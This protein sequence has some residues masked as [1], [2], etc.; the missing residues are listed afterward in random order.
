[1]SEKEAEGYVLGEARE[2][3]EQSKSL[4]EE[5]E[6]LASR[7]SAVDALEV[8]M[9]TVDRAISATEMVDKAKAAFDQAALEGRTRGLNQAE[10]GLASAQA[11]YSS[12][13]YVEAAAAAAE[14][15]QKAFSA[16][17]PVENPFTS[18][19]II[20]ATVLSFI[21]YFFFKNL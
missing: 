7:N 21:G 9:I 16:S 14:A 10:A 2:A 17:K 11:T 8:A 13:K 3:L 6:F 20:A 4:F 12:G 1:M 19:L 5:G 15:Y 18:Q